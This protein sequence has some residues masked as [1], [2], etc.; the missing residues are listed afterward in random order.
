M[1]GYQKSNMERCDLK[2]GEETTEQLNSFNHIGS[3]IT[4]D[5]RSEKEI[6]RWNGM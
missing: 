1:H 6:R 5:G 4:A 2:I 3:L